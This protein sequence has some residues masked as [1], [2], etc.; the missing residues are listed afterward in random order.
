[1]RVSEYKKRVGDIYL[2]M[3]GGCA[4]LPVGKEKILCFVPPGAAKTPEMALS[5]V[6]YSVKGGLGPG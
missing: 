2:H 5:G 4:I 6:F 3:T 1:M